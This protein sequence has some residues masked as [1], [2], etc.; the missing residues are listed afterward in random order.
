MK[1][2]T[3][4]VLGLLFSNYAFCQLV[5]NPQV[6]LTASSL[7]TDP[8]G[9]EA[10]G[11]I[12]YTFGGSVRMGDKIYFNPGIF[13]V[14]STNELTSKSEFGDTSFGEIKDNAT[15]N[16]LHI[17][18][19]VG[20]KLIDTDPFALRIAG[21]PS[22]SWVTSVKDNAFGYTKDV[23]NDKIWGA[24]FGVGVDIL[25][26]TADLSYELG[27]TDLYKFSDAKNNILSLTAGIKF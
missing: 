18:A 21:G 2:I 27:M 5:I 12:G 16:M 13:W 23:Y 22:L 3:F 17:P 11:R 25:F 26:L 6:G 14:K 8:E 15:I 9:T 24:K 4:I 20:V 7:T 19:Q 10:T 1:K